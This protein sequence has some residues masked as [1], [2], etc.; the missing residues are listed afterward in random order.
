MPL[1][2][3]TVKA[4]WSLS[5]FTITFDTDGGSDVDPIIQDYG[6]AITAPADPTKTGHTFA[7]WD[8]EIPATMPADNITIKAKWTVNQ[9]TI[10]FDTNGWS[11]IDPITQDYGTPLIIPNPTKPWY[12]F[13]WWDPALPA[14]VPADNIIVVAQ[15]EKSWWGSS[16]GGWWG[17]SSHKSD[18]WDDQDEQKQD[19]DDNMHGSAWDEEVWLPSESDAN[20]EVVEPEALSAYEWAR[21]YWIT[22]MD[23][24]E[25]A[26]P[27]G[28]VIR[29]HLAK[30][31]VNYM[32]N[33]LWR[34]VPYDVPYECVGWNDDPSIWESDEIKDYATKACALWVMWID[35]RN[36]EFKP[37]DIVTRAEFGTVVSRILWWDKYN[38]SNHWR[39]YRY[40]LHLRALKNEW[41]MTQINKPTRWLEL[42]KWIWVVMMRTQDLWKI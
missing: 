2:G 21:K 20:E 12:T 4:Q 32:V 7:G 22:T 5:G 23:T 42:R 3:L 8:P 19:S 27:N 34:Q 38:T 10:I 17:W 6:T 35:M 14:T 28:Y 26:D 30:M 9:Y 15:W 18:T 11:T 36:N 39:T 13:K 40:T 25:E 33:V 37:N 16:W 31:V 41:I 1:N 24:V 29:W